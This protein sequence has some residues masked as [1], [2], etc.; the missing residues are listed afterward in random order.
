MAAYGENLMATDT[1]HG[2]RSESKRNAA[3]AG[4]VHRPIRA[5]RAFRV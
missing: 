4:I 3:W 2:A 5:F 1:L